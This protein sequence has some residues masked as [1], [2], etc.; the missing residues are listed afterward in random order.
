M[1]AFSS[2]AGIKDG[3]SVG[4]PVPRL[5]DERF[6]TGRG[7]FIDDMQIDGMAHAAIS[8]STHAH[9]RIVAIDASAALALPGVIAVVTA[10]DIA[11]YPG[12]IPIRLGPLPGFQRFLQRPLAS[13]VVRFVGEPVVLLVAESRQIAEDALELLSIDYKPLKPVVSTNEALADRSIIHEKAGTNL[14]SSYRVTD[15]G[16]IDEA[17]ANADYTHK[18]TFRCH[19]QTAVPMETRGL[20]AHFYPN[21]SPYRLRVWGASKVTF[22]NRQALANLIRLPKEEIELIEVDVGGSFGARGEFYPEDFLIPLA[23]MRLGRPVKWIED[24]REHLMATNHS[25]EVECDLEIALKRD[26]TILGLRGWIRTDMGAYIRTNGG[27][28][29]SKAAQ[30]IPGPYH[31]PSLWFEVQ[32]LITN[33]TPIGTFRGPGMFEGNFFRERLLDIAAADLGLSPLEI[34]LRNLIK[35]T[36]MPY[37]APQLVPHELSDS[38]DSGDY[39]AALRHALDTIGYDRLL[40]KC[41]ADETIRYGVGIACYVESTGAGPS[42]IARLTLSRNGR[43]TVNI[44]ISASGQGHETIF[45]QIAADELSVAPQDVA[46]AHGSTS[47]VEHSYG[48]FHSRGAVMGGNAVLL[49]ARKLRETLLTL[50]SRRLNVGEEELELR[51]G[52]IYAVRDSGAALMSFAALVAVAREIEPGIVNGDG[53]IEITA[54]FKQKIKTFGYGTHVAHVAVDIETGKIDVLRYIVV[55]DIGN[56]INPLITHGQVIGGAVQ[57][58]GSVFLDEIV[59]DADGQLLT[60][61]LADYLVA[62]STEFPHVEAV[63]L[64]LSPST[65]NPLG[66][67]GAGEGGIVATGAALAN[68][69]AHALAPLGVKITALPLNPNNIRRILR[70]AGH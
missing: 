16:D 40:E 62:T 53:A 32:A 13:G 69:V 49:A 19:R 61:S 35:S 4:R 50:A 17:F 51:D 55:E 70:D 10:A 23:A 26:G 12:E 52:S 1:N 46:V 14:A 11:D 24:R 48:T 38:Y 41:G 30:F 37:R 27:V 8:R 28:V 59:Y 9:A 45:A 29:P 22:F 5:E 56:P 36:E 7:C 54:K 65:L 34:R 3:K 43:V 25:R 68:A 33:K 58:I 63:S 18:E 64:N 47:L 21:G 60:G 67:K 20:L 6:L 44:G 42:E 15:G 66:V 31:I 39:I 57:G 2:P